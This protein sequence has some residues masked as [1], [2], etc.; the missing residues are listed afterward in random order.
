M[1]IDIYI[2]CEMM[3]V[4]NLIKHLSPHTVIFFLLWQK[5]LRYTV[6]A[7]LSLI[8]HSNT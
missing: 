7:N 5:V 6:L 4:I 8:I 2:D 3:N 1:M